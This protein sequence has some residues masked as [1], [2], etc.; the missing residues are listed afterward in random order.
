MHGGHALNL[1]PSLAVRGVWL[2]A[3]NGA[4]LQEAFVA[5]MHHDL[6]AAQL[7]GTLPG[8]QAGVRRT[9]HG[10]HSLF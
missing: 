8:N 3:G 10:F 2:F 9:Q 7:S 1:W 4:A 5:G 6:S